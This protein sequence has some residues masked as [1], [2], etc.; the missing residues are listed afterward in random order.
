MANRRDSMMILRMRT[1]LYDICP[2]GSM[3]DRAA[4]TRRLLREELARF[5]ESRYRAGCLLRIRL[6]PRRRLDGRS[7]HR[8]DWPQAWPMRADNRT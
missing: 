3:G 4:R 6:G 2:R 5:G 1:R 7:A 8:G